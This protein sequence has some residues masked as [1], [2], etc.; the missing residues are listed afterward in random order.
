M[1]QKQKD[2]ECQ[3]KILNGKQNRTPRGTAGGFTLV[4]T[5][6]AIAISGILISALYSCFGFGFAAVRSTRDDLQATQVLLTSM[7]RIRLCTW[8]QVSSQLYNPLSST[9]YFDN[10]NHR[11]P[12]TVSFKA[13]VPPAG[14][15]PD[16]Y[17]NEML[18]VTV[19]V[20]WMSGRNLRQR[21]MQSY[22]AKD[23]MRDYVTGS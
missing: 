13:T 14:S 22:F 1:R 4:E 19:K 5:I 23:G 17:R 11:I 3:M 2:K 20:S 12:A 15:V 10:K 6:F 7:E 18:L 9:V 21:T 8:A 16:A